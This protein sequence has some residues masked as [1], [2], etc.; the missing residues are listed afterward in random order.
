MAIDAG[1][2][3]PLEYVNAASTPKAMMSGRSAA[4]PE[5]VTPSAPTTTWM[6]TSCSAMYGSV[7][8]MPVTVTASAS[9]RL[10]NRPRTKSAAVM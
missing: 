2:R 8:T 3:S 4:M 7:A 9:H 5:P 6:P 10:P 1:A